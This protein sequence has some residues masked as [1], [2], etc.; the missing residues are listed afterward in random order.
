MGVNA[1]RFLVGFTLGLLDKL[2]LFS[3]GPFCL[4]CGQYPGNDEESSALGWS[5]KLTGEGVFI[6]ALIAGLIVGNFFPGLPN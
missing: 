2:W 1:R 3:F 5:L 6:V 4:F